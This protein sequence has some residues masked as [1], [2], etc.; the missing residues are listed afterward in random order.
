[1]ETSKMVIGR[2]SKLDKLVSGLKNYVS[3]AQADPTLPLTILAISRTIGVKKSTIYLHQREPEVAEQL[4]LIRR[5]AI[6]RRRATALDDAAETLDSDLHLPEAD[7]TSEGEN[8][9]LVDLDVLAVRAGRAVQKAVWSMNRF[10]GRHRK[11]RYM[12]DLP[13]VVYDL[14]MALAELRLIRGEVGTLCDDWRQIARD[15]TADQEVA[16]QLILPDIA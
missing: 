7:M 12:S 5:L 13:R 2:P 8:A 9:R 15:A 10:I 4:N 16:G 14:D 11:H 3:E 1:M 6:A